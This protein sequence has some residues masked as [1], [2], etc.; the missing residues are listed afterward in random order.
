MALTNRRALYIGVATHCS[1]KQPVVPA[2]RAVPCKPMSITAR[3]LQ[4]N[5][6]CQR[7]VRTPAAS[8]DDIAVYTEV[9][10]MSVNDQTVELDRPRA[11]VLGS[12]W[13]SASFMKALPK[14]IKERFEV[15]VVSPRNYFLYTPLLPAV[16][17]GTMEER[18]I[19]EPVRNLV[20][21]KGDYYEAVCKAIDPVRKEL[22]ACFPK[23]SGLDEA[24][25]KISYDVLIIGVSTAVCC[26]TPGCGCCRQACKFAW[27]G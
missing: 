10:N 18:S 1:F 26:L 16:A 6:L 13:A 23:D 9:K 27:H 24:C 22:V 19:V 25:F 20:H 17:V 21:G 2:A 7:H 12:G 14:D 8:V 4:S 11:V 15:V 5:G 3:V